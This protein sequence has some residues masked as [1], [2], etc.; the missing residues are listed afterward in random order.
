MSDA[1]GNFVSVKFKEF[2]RNLNTEQVLSSSYH[3]KFHQV[4]VCITFINLTSKK[5]F[6]TNNDT[7]LA[8]LQRRSTPLGSG[9]PSPATSLY[10]QAIRGIMPVINRVPIN[11]TNDCDHYEALVEGKENADK[12]Y[13]TVTNYNSISIESTVPVQWEDGDHRPMETSMTKVTTTTMM[14]TGWLITTT[15]NIWRQHPSRLGSTWW[16]PGIHE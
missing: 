10:N 14:K 2:C 16:T 15:A 5:Y 3:T 8:L 11:S 9:L 7:Y 1:D 4:K 13:D 6:N 12:N